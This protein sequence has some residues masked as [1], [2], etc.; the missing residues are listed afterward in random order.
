VL[1]FLKIVPVW[2]EKESGKQL[3][4][5][6]MNR[7]KSSPESN[8]LFTFYN[9]LKVIILIIEFLNILKEKVIHNKNIILQAREMYLEYGVRLSKKI[10]DEKKLYQMLR[11]LDFE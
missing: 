10:T 11:D 1:Y 7:L 5:I 4:N 6:L 9:P 3:A 8:F 2:N